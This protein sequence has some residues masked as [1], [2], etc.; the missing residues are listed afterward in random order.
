MRAR[1]V[2]LEVAQHRDGA[3]PLEVGGM[4]GVADQAAAVV[5]VLG[6]EAEE[7]EGDLAVATGDED[8]HGDQAVGASASAPAS[9]LTVRVRFGGNAAL[10]P[11]KSRV[12]RVRIRR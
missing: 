3:D 5:A 1:V 12:G 2:V 7:V 8:I 9:R 4:V 6:E 11:A 10:T